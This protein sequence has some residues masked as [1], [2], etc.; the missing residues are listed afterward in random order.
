MK[1][2]GKF[3]NLTNGGSASSAG[4][5][6]NLNN[7]PNEYQ[8]AVVYDLVSEGPIEGLV[9]GTNSI[10]LDKTG[11]TIS[12][13]KNQTISI[14][15]AA[16]VASSRTLTDSSSENLFTNIAVADG[17]R[18]IS[19]EGGKKALAANGS[20]TGVS[21]TVG[22]N[23][24]TTHSGSGFFNVNDLNSANPQSAADV[25]VNGENPHQYI[26][27]EGAGYESST[28]VLVAKIIKF[29]DAQTVEI[30]VP[31]PR[32][33]AHKAVTID[34]VAT[35]SS[36]TNANVLVVANISEYGTDNRNVTGVEAVLNSPIETDDDT[37]YNFEQFQYAFMNGTRAQPWL[38]TFK[39]IGSSSVVDGPNQVI[40]AT[41]LSSIIGSNNHTTTG[42]WN[43]TAGSA[44]ASSV[45]INS[46][47]VSS[48]EE[49]DKVKLTF[50]FANMI[51]T[52]SSSGDEAS[53]ICELRIFFGFKRA[54]DNKFTESI[55]FGIND[56][57]LAARGAGNYTSAWK[58]SNNSGRITAE[59]KAP[60]LETFTINTKD[61]QPYSSYQIRI[62]RIGPSS[63][64][65]GDYD[66]S[67]PCTLQT[68]EHILEDKLSYPY[69]AYGALIFDAESF[70]KIPKRS[71]DIKGLLVQVPTNYFPKG[72]GN[73]ATG[74]YDRNV[75]NATNTGTYQK[76]DGN[77]RGDLS[78]F[79]PG[80]VNANKV[81]TDNPAWIFYDLISNNRYGLGK[82]IDATQID[83]YALFRIARYCDE[84]VADGKGGTEP[85]FTAN[86][87]LKESA[88]ALKV[89]QDV[90]ST[91][92][93][94]MYWLDGEVQFSQ[95][96][97]EQPVYTF[98]KANVIGDFKYTSTKQQFR[99]NQIRVTWN[100]PESMFKQQ[101]EVVEDTNNILQTSRIVPKDVVAF[102]CTSKGQ[103]H[104]FGK[105]NLFSEI[106]ET[107]GISFST[108]INA[109]FLKPGDVVLVQDAD[110]DNVRYSG[111]IS[112]SST[113][114]DINI[115]SA[116]NLSGGN[117]FKLSI[118][119]PEGGAYLA[120]ELRTIN[121]EIG[122]SNT[123]VYSRGDL[124]R[125][126]KVNG[127]VVEITSDDQASNAVDSSGA[128]LDLVWNP[129]SRVETQTITSTGSSATT[130]VTSAPFSSAPSQD[131]MWAIR[132]YDST[133]NL[134]NGSAQQY[135]VTGISQKEITQHV[136]TAIKYE[137]AKFDLI[138]RGY[139]L[140]QGIDTQKLPSYNE[141]VPTPTALTLSL[142]KNLNQGVEDSGQS[143][144]ALRNKIKVNWTSPVNSNNTKYQHISHYEIKHN[145]ESETKFKKVV[146]GKNDTSLI[147]PYAYPKLITVKIQA[148]NT[149][150]TKSNIVQRKIKILNSSLENT[151]SKIGL[152]PKGGVLNRAIT[153][154]S[155]TISVSNYSYQYDAPNG[156]TYNN[157]TNSA[158]CYQQNFNGMGAN[159]EAFLLFDASESSDKLK[160]VQIHTDTT[161]QDASGNTPGYNYIKEVG[162][163]N[164]GV[165]QASGTVTGTKGDNIITGSSA[166]FDG[167][168]IPGDRI[169][170][171]AAG[172]TR[173]YSTVAFI[174]GN[175]E[176]Q[177]SDTLPRAYSGVNVFRL[178]FRPD[179]NAD[180]IIAKVITDGS[181]NYS[182]S[183]TYAVTAGLD[184]A[185][186]GGVDARAVKLNAST[187]AVRYESGSPPSNLQITLTAIAQGTAVTP[188]FDYFKSTDQGGTFSQITTDHSG[189]TLST[190][191]ASF[192]LK[193]ADEPALE[194]DVLIRVRM[195]EGGTLKATDTIT[196]FAVQD[197]AGGTG[198]ITGNLTNAAHT[199]STDSNGTTSASGFYANA[200]GA[201]ETF[202][203]A[204]AVSTNS[205]VLFYTGTSGTSLT[206]TQNGLTLTLTQATGAYAL[207]GSSWSSNAET[208]TVRAL[209]PASV[210]GGTGTKTLTR[211]Y[212]ISK[213]KAGVT[214]GDGDNGLR[215]IQGYLY[216]ESTSGAPS[217]PSGSTYTFS[218]GVVTGTG[219]STATTQPNNV[220]LNSPN[221]QDATSSNVHYTLRYYGQEAN[222]NDP[223]IA[224]AYSNVVQL[225]SFS[226][227]VTF[228]GGTLTDGTTSKTPI[229]AG[230]VAAHIGG[231]NTT[232][233]DGSKITTGTISSNNL[234]GTS[235]GSAF[236]TAGTRI[237]LS[238]GAIASKNF[239]I[240]SD[241]SSEF[242]GTLKIGSSTLTADNTL[243]AN[244]DA[245]DLG[246]VYSNNSLGPLTLAANKI[247][248]GTG[249][250][251]NSNTG[252]YIDNSGNFSLKDKL[253]FNGS[254]LT[255]N[256]TG[257]F[258]GTLT[259]STGTFGDATLSSTG[260]A[261]SGT[262]SSINLGSGN[263]VATG[264]G[265]VTAKNLTLTGSVSGGLSSGTGTGLVQISQGSTIFRAGADS[266]SPIEVVKTGT[267]SVVKLNNV[268]IYNASGSKVF[269]S[270][271]GF[272]DEFFSGIAQT[273]GT[274]VSTISKTVTN[275][276]A[277]ADAQKVVLTATQTLTISASKPA[278][279][280]GYAFGTNT[281][282]PEA[283]NKIP[284]KVQMRLMVSTNSDL[285]NPSPLANLGTSF[286]SGVTR[287]TGTASNIKYKV[288]EE[289]ES[290]PGFRFFEAHVFA[291]N[292]P[293]L[294]PTGNFVISDTDS[295]T[296][297]TY[298]FFIEI[299]GTAGTQTV[300]INNV[301]N[302]VASRT[303]SISAAT[304]ES[305]YIDESGDGS[306][307]SG[308]DIT[309]VIAGNGLVGGAL[310]GG[311]TLNVVGGT[312][313]TANSND[314]ALTD[315][316]VTAGNYTNTNLTVDAQGRITSA[317]N[318]TGGYSLPLSS[319]STRGG[320]KIGYSE[321]GKNYP[322][323]LS[324][325]KMYVNV[326][327][328]DTIT[329]NTNNY[330]SGATYNSGTGVLTLNRTGL[331]SLTVNVG[332]DTNT[333]RAI[334]D[335]PVNGATTTSISSNWAFDNVK[336]SVPS[337]AVFTDTNTQLSTAQ[338]RAKVSG[339]GLI[340]YNSSTGVI[341]TTANNI[342]NNN[343]IANGAGYT[344]NTGTTT[345]SNTQTFT[346][347]GGNITQWTNNAG[348]TTNTGTTTA[349][350][351]Q[352]FTNKS[353]NISQWTNNSNYFVKGL[354]SPLQASTG[355]FAG[356][357]VAGGDVTAF[358]DKKLKDNI[359][360]LDG[361]KVFDMRGVS[362]TRN[363]LDNK[364][365]SGVIAQELEK[366]APELV[367]EDED[368]IKGVAYGN[369]VGYL[370]E[371]VK[372]LKEEIEE[373]KSGN[374][375]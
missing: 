52:K 1:N 345:A 169:V 235:D 96:R 329:T 250:F 357:I 91:F 239:R 110:V 356:A 183:E 141:V 69:A 186:G 20:S 242:R 206:S 54:G 33:I 174:S 102:G 27:I 269:S 162:A 247:H 31:L 83:K 240:A 38:N 60:F 197:G 95:N 289:S 18:Y 43:T 326:P 257:T 265:A 362:F 168:F 343:Q 368:G 355:Q 297:G 365:S 143:S 13:T 367:H 215:S 212:T 85:R 50:S 130:L 84:L 61:F 87:Y 353:G 63:A 40:E 114:D 351:T 89:L 358:S 100:D 159:A 158:A 129:N 41:N 374:R 205:S 58:H 72:E 180:G 182:I 272:S 173:F 10:Y 258:A 200:G 21:G 268:E 24:I 156:I 241:G 120:D 137:P 23:R 26:R 133:G 151:L 16:Y 184:G 28:S 107:E 302:T 47:N 311:A 74:E 99:S 154:N 126:A 64:K 246:G 131:Y 139:V 36:I 80:H 352:T 81:W 97:Y 124:I 94:M 112:A 77:F 303:I 328:T 136:I 171:G 226:G 313:I 237:T 109:G 46:S 291:S 116:V 127:T 192:V 86:L 115:D 309:A 211:K 271:D 340:S 221:T 366:I 364:E 19:I 252:F 147:L 216:Y 305:F 267:A 286:T 123:S 191:T 287:T 304:G 293:N 373:L 153:L 295:Y 118:I 254:A 190:T 4:S 270:A 285:S 103:A 230:D 150:G 307:A 372:L 339:T 294:L 199:V 363:D 34:K 202:V 161:A 140:E 301:S 145:A 262:G 335:T 337:G 113:T 71:Y 300:G 245:D 348:Y 217:A 253:S 261:I 214:P 135:V 195:Y 49:V 350:N 375:E 275:A 244:T 160:A 282:S 207:T 203:G 106:M 125:F 12:N 224:V 48:P 284:A 359:L 11:A 209:I 181:T 334:H 346:N 283:L 349:S 73:R 370:I 155:S 187:Y 354:T 39:G 238:N 281:Q 6:S 249:T 213:S 178:T 276:S 30:D 332:V 229:E 320:V 62:E 157:T 308:G 65:H 193:N 92:R 32:T 317:A 98:S 165:T 5:D 14:I 325:E 117:T 338:V 210:H 78:T 108:S 220:W 119:Y 7:S 296:A 323:E 360:T 288:I 15:N 185:A 236:T 324:S 201:F 45:I 44:T 347:K 132:E 336:T 223:T 170:I 225:T 232:T 189:N 37:H 9:D 3:Y 66:H 259:G 175:N 68:V 82:Y 75:T 264:A 166:D 330:I 331:S 310:S 142:S 22:T 322:V 149:T 76:W 194:G 88:E 243:N 218:S 251:N 111:R 79:A 164:N 312:G 327:W 279:M 306:E 67:S 369:V 53:A 56:A 260:L 172:T 231:A 256:G 176:I 292:N 179:T 121:D 314:I 57:T 233:I 273:T 152:I 298:Y 198:G 234:S 315:T 70:A 104:R 290:E 318:G 263:F 29:I 219:I 128:V 93:G 25:E 59:T 163:S 51:A 148:V 228:S 342:T 42:G 55:V 361:S 167:E 227:V 344:T 371:A 188:T 2:L 333:F 299:G 280:S 274:A 321:N 138:D 319:S 122:N 101:V 266:D 208:F 90:A 144:E 277:E 105:W 341:S 134:A 196:I 17:L 35:V 316:S 278:E 248:T 222:E 146:A 177:L 255:V 8:T 204:T